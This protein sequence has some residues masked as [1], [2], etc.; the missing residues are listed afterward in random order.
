MASDDNAQFGVIGMAVMGRNLALNIADHGYKVAVFN[1]H[2]PESE[3][4]VAESGKAGGPKMRAT[5]TLEE[6]VQSLERPRKIMMM[7][8]AGAPVDQVM[9]QLRPMLDKGD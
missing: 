9:D 7:I 1:R 2:F 8:K 5:R 4:A 6:F 3:R